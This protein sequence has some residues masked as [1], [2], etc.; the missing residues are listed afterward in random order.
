MIVGISLSKRLADKYGK[1][2]V[3]K[4]GLLVATFFIFDFFFYE[5]RIQKKLQLAFMLCKQIMN[6]IPGVNRALEEGCF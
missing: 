4:Y 2:D 3:Y 5:S 1:R 6:R